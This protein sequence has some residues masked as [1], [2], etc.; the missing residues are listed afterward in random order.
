MQSVTAFIKSEVSK[1]LECRSIAI[2]ATTGNGHDT[3]FLAATAKEV[4]GF[5][6]QEK[7]IEQTKRMLREQGLNN[8]TLHL[9]SHDQLDTAGIEAP[10]VIMFNFGYLPGSYKTTTTKKETSLRAVEK[11]CHMVKAGGIITLALYPG[12]PE[13]ELETSALKAYAASLERAR[14]DV[15]L[16]DPFNAV[17]SPCAIIIEKRKD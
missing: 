11:A 4:H 13:G 12:H 1:K 8:A 15:V 5:D 10:D 16:Y 7:A 2:D 17:K 9:M 14:Y 3:V 6:I